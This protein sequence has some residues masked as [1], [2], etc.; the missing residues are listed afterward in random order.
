MDIC[1]NSVWFIRNC[2][3][4]RHQRMHSCS[5]MS[6]VRACSTAW[7]PR[8]AQSMP[9]FSP[10]LWRLTDWP[11]KA[12]VQQKRKLRWGLQS[13][14]SSP[15]FNS[16][17]LLRPT[18]QWETSRTPQLTSRPTRL[19]SRTRFSKNLSLRR[20]PTPSRSAAQQVRASCYRASCSDVDGCF[21][22]HWTSWCTLSRGLVGSFQSPRPRKV[23]WHCSTSSGPAC[24]T[25]VSQS[26]QKGG[27][28]GALWWRCA[29]TD[30]FLKAAVAARSL[31]RPR[32]PSVLFRPSS[33]SGQPLR[34]GL[35]S[36]PAGRVALIYPRWVETHRPH[37]SSVNLS[38]HPLHSLQRPV[39]TKAA[40]MQQKSKYIPTS[41]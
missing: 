8:R 35:A 10:L 12:Q 34:G 3:G 28:C 24:A 36:K 9:L 16:P 11:S 26:E 40:G 7:C 33:T 5:W 15:S 17:M 41:N 22:T 37:L 23:Q 2:P 27:G 31:P 14:H 1:V 20:A 18:W 25:P 39:M 4:L 6:F 19:S 13:W 29:W 38:W 30:V 32:Q 21:D